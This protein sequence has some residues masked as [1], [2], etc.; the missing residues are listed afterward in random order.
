MLQ[1]DYIQRLIREFMAAIERMLEK[2][3]VASRREEIRRLCEQYVGPYDFYSVATLDDVMKAL[4]GIADEDERLAKMEMLAELY[5]QEAY[6]ISKPLGD[7][8]LEKSFALYSYIEMHGRT[9]SIQRR[10]KM[11]AIS[12]ELHKADNEKV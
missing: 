3:E 5:W 1:R 11:A 12:A 9:Y 7:M 6:L 10:Q 2:K 8:L 4:S